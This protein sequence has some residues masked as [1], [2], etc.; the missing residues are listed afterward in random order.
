MTGLKK[1]QKLISHC[2]KRVFEF[3][4]GSESMLQRNRSYICL[5]LLDLSLQKSSWKANYLSG[6]WEVSRT[7]LKGVLDLYILCPIWEGFR[8]GLSAQLTNPIFI[9][10]K[11]AQSL[12]FFSCFV[13][14]FWG[15]IDVRALNRCLFTFCFIFRL[16]NPPL[17]Y[18]KLAKFYISK[19]TEMES[20]IFLAQLFSDYWWPSGKMASFYLEGLG[21]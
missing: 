18:E 16:W 9:C 7:W 17:Q 19:P 10:L 14:C 21:I 4:S 3:F 20:A 2:Q 8:T 5:E 15:I 12:N 6:T 1:F 13:I 11:S